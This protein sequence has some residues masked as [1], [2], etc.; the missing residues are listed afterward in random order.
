MRKLSTVL[1]TL[2]NDPEL[3]NHFY[4]GM[5]TSV[6]E[7][8]VGERIASIAKPQVYSYGRLFVK[9]QSASWRNELTMMRQSICDR[10]N[11]AL[12]AQVV[13]TIIFR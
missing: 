13:Q 10:I 9:V 1:D 2:F 12:G 6:W 3:K 4:K 11:E 5:V 7:D 8:A